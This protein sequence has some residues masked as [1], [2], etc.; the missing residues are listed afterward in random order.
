[1]IS[2]K[3]HQK[4]FTL[5]E[6][7]VALAITAVI[8]VGI[9]AAVVQVISVNS[10]ATHHILAIKQVENV[11]YW[12]NHDL[13]MAQAVQ[14]GGGSGFPLNLSWTEWNNTTHQVSYS[15]TDNEMHRSY[16]SNGT[17][18]SGLVIG[19][20]IDIDSNKTN[21][22]YLNG[23]FTFKITASVTGFKPASETRLSQVI[24]RSAQ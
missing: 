23:V 14:V 21:C 3:N 1:M 2:L 4:G 7:L 13:R 16:T 17:A 5:I 20:Y 15:I 10:I 9:S 6:M 19:Q 12:L 22:Q 11:S 24:P 18:T 8:G